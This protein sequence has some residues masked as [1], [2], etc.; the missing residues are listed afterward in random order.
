MFGIA[1][2]LVAPMGARAQD[3]GGGLGAGGSVGGAASI[4]SGDV[5]TGGSASGGAPAPAPSY[6]STSSSDSGFEESAG[7]SSGTRLGLQ[8]RLDALNLIGPGGTINIG[9]PGGISIGGPIDVGIGPTVPLVTPG[10]RFVDGKLFLGFGL[11]FAGGSNDTGGPGG[12]G[13]RGQSGFSVSP[14]VSYD[15]VTDAVAALHLAGWFN[16]ASLGEEETCNAAG[17][18]SDN[19]GSDADGLG[20]NVAAGVRGKLSEGLAIGGE[21]GWGFMSGS[22]GTADYFNHGLIGTLLFEASVGL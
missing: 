1:A 12:G 4:E 22:V 5:D 14:L 2:A 11:G 19:A 20:L 6:A 15:L 13:D 17:T 21:F 10:V 3:Q 18:C 16:L 9:G 7:G 8:V